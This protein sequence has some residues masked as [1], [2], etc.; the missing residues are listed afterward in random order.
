MTTPRVP[1]AAASAAGR[2]S[3][4]ARAMAWSRAVSGAGVG[5]S[6]IGLPCDSMTDAA[7]SSGRSPASVQPN[8]SVYQAS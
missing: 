4:K 5:A 7:P 1:R 3:P 8:P 2:S 6:A